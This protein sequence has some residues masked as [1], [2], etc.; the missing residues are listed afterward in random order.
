M[1]QKLISG[2]AHFYRDCAINEAVAMSH[3]QIFI[4]G[5]SLQ[6]LDCV[7]ITLVKRTRAEDSQENSS[8]G[9]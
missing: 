1:W 7:Q 4:L 8:E 2:Y 5:I 9:E 3:L 6:H